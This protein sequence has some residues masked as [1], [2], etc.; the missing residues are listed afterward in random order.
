MSR[1]PERG[2]PVLPARADGVALVAL[3]AD[4]TLRG[5]L[6]EPVLPAVIVPVL[7]LV[8]SLVQTC[9]GL[10]PHRHDAGAPRPQGATPAAARA[11]A[12]RFARK[13]GALKRAAL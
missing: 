9:L 3:L 11:E 12:Q 1:L 7:L 13:W 4:G 2:R 5:D 8:A 10:A 6:D